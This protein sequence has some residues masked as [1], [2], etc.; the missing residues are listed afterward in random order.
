LWLETDQPAIEQ[1]AEMIRRIRGSQPAF[2]R[3]LASRTSA[4]GETEQDSKPPR[5]RKA[6][7]QFRVDGERLTT[8]VALSHRHDYFIDC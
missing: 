7:E 8:V 2:M 6:T 4:V 3:E 5:I 1:A